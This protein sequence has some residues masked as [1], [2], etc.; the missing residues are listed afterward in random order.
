M[1]NRFIS[2]HS[3]VMNTFYTNGFGKVIL[4]DDREQFWYIHD[5]LFCR[6]TFNAKNG[7][8]DPAMLGL[9]QFITKGDVP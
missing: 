2:A 3:N 8:T 6:R 1:K 4:G 9:V 7:I 5:G